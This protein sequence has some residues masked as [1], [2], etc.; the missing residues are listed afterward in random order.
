MNRISLNEYNKSEIVIMKLSAHG[1]SLSLPD[2]ISERE[3]K[4]IIL[5]FFTMQSVSH[6][7]KRGATHDQS[8]RLVCKS[9][10]RSCENYPWHDSIANNDNGFCSQSRIYV[11]LVSWRK[12]FPYARSANLNLI[13]YEKRPFLALQKFELLQGLRALN[14]GRCVSLRNAH[15]T[16]F[17]SLR[18]LDVRLCKQVTDEAFRGL[19]GLQSL[20]V[21]G[22]SLLTGTCF[23]WLHGLYDLNMS[24][25]R[26]IIELKPGIKCLIATNCEQLTQDM[27][28]ESVQFLNVSFCTNI[29]GLDKLKEISR[30]EMIG[31]RQ[32]RDLAQLKEL[33]HLNIACCSQLTAGNILALRSLEWINVYDCSQGLQAAARQIA[34]EVESTSIWY[35]RYMYCNI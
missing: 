21:A 33:T 25:C 24:Y 19:G 29:T 23:Q 17:Q 1:T 10:L 13:S 6:R 3:N 5:S 27:L 2:V 34:K 30:L 28:P 4:G 22:C 16:N 7:S 8:L 18:K 15:F 12:C 11:D 9:I 35:D 31:C 26:N 32:I 14:L 20:N